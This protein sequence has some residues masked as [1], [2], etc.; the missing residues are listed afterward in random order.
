MNKKI[1][2]LAAT[3]AILLSAASVFA[4]GNGK[5]TDPGVWINYGNIRVE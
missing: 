4:K 3:G 5:D 1:A 2:A